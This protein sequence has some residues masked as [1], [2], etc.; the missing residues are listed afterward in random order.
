MKPFIRIL[1]SGVLIRIYIC[2]GIVG[3]P[4]HGYFAQ[5]TFDLRGIPGPYN[6]HKFQRLLTGEDIRVAGAGEFSYTTSDGS[7]RTRVGKVDLNSVFFV[8]QNEGWVVGTEGGI[9]RTADRGRN[10]TREES[11]VISELLAISCVGRTRCWVAGE[12]GVVLTT[13]NGKDWTRLKLKTKSHLNAIDFLDEKVGLVVGDNAVILR[14]YDGGV[15][16]RKESIAGGEEAC[17]GHSFSDNASN[18]NAVTILDTKHA[19]IAGF[20]G[21][22]RYLANERRWEGT[23]LKEVGPLVGIVTQGGTNIYAIGTA[24][25]NMLSQ[26][27]GITWERFP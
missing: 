11:G 17:H 14:T 5:D 7:F 20:Y 4:S 2:V 1:C 27:A 18:L 9:Y 3:V 10:W 15:N 26:N 13:K 21:I 19:Y 22:A 24:G 12:N 25:E 8:N 6:F 16:W 23:C